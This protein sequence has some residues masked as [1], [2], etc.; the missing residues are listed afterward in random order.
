[1]GE[2][3]SLTKCPSKARDINHHDRACCC[4]LDAAGRYV[5]LLANASIHDQEDSHIKHGKKLAGN[6][7]HKRTLTADVVDEEESAKHS[8]YE[9]DLQIEGLA[10]CLEDHDGLNP[11]VTYHTK[12][13]CREELFLAAGSSHH[14]KV[15]GS[16]DGDRRGA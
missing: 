10:L 1:M 13:G 6:T 4:R 15:F 7:D 2:L 9:L 5:A 3:G 8:R 16:V 14:S 12:N 11:S